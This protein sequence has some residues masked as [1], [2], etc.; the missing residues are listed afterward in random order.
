MEAGHI[1]LGMEAFGAANASQWEIITD[2]IDNTDYYVLVIG[3]RYGSINEDTGLSFTEMEFD[4]ALSKNIP[5]LV[6][7]M[8]EGVSVDPKF[9]DNPEL[10]SKFKKRAMHNRQS[11]FWKSGD[12]LAAKVIKALTAEFR[13]T[14]RLG[15]IRPP[16][17][18]SINATEEF[19]QISKENRGSC[20]I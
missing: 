16:Q 19:A 8:A 13:R 3:A 10:L 11:D 14:P 6:L 18:L 12:D 9:V 2:T 17:T 1:P 4:Y 5:C 15:W 7:S 20:W